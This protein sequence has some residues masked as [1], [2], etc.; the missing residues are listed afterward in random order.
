MSKRRNED[1]NSSRE[2]L[3]AKITDIQ[4]MMS[5]PLPKDLQNIPFY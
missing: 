3:Y 2:S 1:S 4:T 5:C